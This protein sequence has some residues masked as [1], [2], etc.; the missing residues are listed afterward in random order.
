MLGR[1][2][3]GMQA[4]DIRSI[5]WHMFTIGPKLQA[6]FDEPLLAIVSTLNN[7]GAAEMTPIWWEFHDGF[8]WFN[9]TATRQWLSRMESTGRATFFL[10]DAQNGWRWAQVWGRVVA[11]GDDPDV[12]HFGRLGQRYGRPIKPPIPDR[13]YLKIEITSVK[14][15]A[16][17]P[18]EH[19]DV[20]A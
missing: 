11:A 3:A 2:D 15:R 5:V 4:W 17:N 18:S 14:G 13:R 7:R 12:V 20:S 9:G 16:G 19:W 1:N 6:F 8:V 10:M